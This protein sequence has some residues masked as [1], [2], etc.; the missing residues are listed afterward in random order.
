VLVF[1]IVLT[2][3]VL[4]QV[5]A[6][7]AQN[8]QVEFEH[9]QR[10]QADMLDLDRAVLQSA[11]GDVPGSTRIEMS[12]RYPSRFFLLNPSVRSGTVS[13]LPSEE[14]TIRNAESPTA[15]NYLT[16][17]SL[18]FSTRT[19][20]YRPS[21]QEYQNPPN[22]VY[23]HNSLVNAFDEETALPVDSGSFIDGSKI[24]LVTV[25]GSFARS[26]TSSVALETTP[27]SAPAQTVPV[28]SGSGDPITLELPTTLSNSSWH[29]VLEDEL[30]ENGGQ[31]D[32]LTVVEGDP[33]NTLEVTLSEGTYDLRMARVAVGGSGDGT[34][35][36]PHYLAATDG[37]DG[38]T[39]RHG[40]TR[41]LDVQVRD[42]FNNAVDGEVTWQADGGTFVQADGSPVSTLEDVQ[43]ED[44]EASVLFQL[45]AETTDEAT[46]TATIGDPGGAE[47]RETVTFT[48]PVATDPTDGEPPVDSP[49]DPDDDST[50]NINPS[51]Q[52][53]VVLEGA[54]TANG[55][56]NVVVTFSN[57]G[58]T[59]TVERLR[60]LFY[61]PGGPQNGVPEEGTING[62]SVPVAG[63]WVTLDEPITISSTGT[64]SVT[65]KFGTNANKAFFG[66]AFDFD[67]GHSNYFVQVD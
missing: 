35:V 14:I 61:M 23:E 47:P 3:L 2:L 46:V 13:T 39:L 6:V 11:T 7:P 44:G 28:T 67:Q 37:N 30:A 33:Y 59:R 12:A 40:E 24:V 18:S 55:N 45:D 36:Q 66:L 52:G 65:I 31:I 17:D 9:N 10:V 25:D 32:D 21:Y 16:G 43:T 53:N 49:D 62:Q 51:E 29:R 15:G 42:K 60:L 41:S 27:M 56:Q 58:T 54:T 64:T 38:A 57:S 63:R 22:T 8:Q 34:Q 19:V 20:Q 48:I 1:G 26:S 4:I 50:S 5:N